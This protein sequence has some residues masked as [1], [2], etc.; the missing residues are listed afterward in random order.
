[1][2]VLLF[3]N[4]HIYIHGETLFLRHLSYIG[5]Y[6]M[7]SKFSV[8]HSRPLAVSYACVCVNPDLSNLSLPPHFP[9][10]SHSLIAR[11]VSLSLSWKQVHLCDFKS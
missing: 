10:G 11:S 5:C 3:I 6:T 8:L 2:H 9:F 4:I 7:L 1:M